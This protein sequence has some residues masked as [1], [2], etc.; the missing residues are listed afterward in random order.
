[1][2][3]SIAHPGCAHKSRCHRRKPILAED[4]AHHCVLQIVFTEINS[5]GL[6]RGT[7]RKL[8]TDVASSALGTAL[9]A[10]WAMGPAPPAALLRPHRHRHQW[11][12]HQPE[13]P[14]RTAS[15]WLSSGSSLLSHS[16]IHLDPRLFNIIRLHGRFSPLPARLRMILGRTTGLGS[17]TTSAALHE[18]VPP[19]LNFV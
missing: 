8:G 13:G 5:F 14:Q 16:S 6:L 7:T 12:P 3:Q 2:V 4:L 10:P 15:P 18:A 19:Q 11:S 1:M 9:S 17:H